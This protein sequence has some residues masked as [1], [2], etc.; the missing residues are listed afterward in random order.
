MP[1]L[2][3]DD[4][5]AFNA[6][7]RNNLRGLREILA[8]HPAHV[9]KAWT[10]PSGKSLIQVAEEMGTRVADCRLH[11]KSCCDSEGSL[12]MASP[13][14]S[15]SPKLWCTSAEESAQVP[16]PQKFR[17]TSA[18]MVEEICNATVPMESVQASTL[19]VSSV[20]PV[21]K[22]NVV[23][24]I[25]EVP[26]LCEK[27]IVVEVP[28][29]H[30]LKSMKYV[31]KVKIEEIHEQ[32]EVPEINWKEDIR[33][34]PEW[35]QEDVVKRVSVDTV[36]EVIKPIF[37]PQVEVQEEIVEVPVRL[38]TME[39]IIEKPI[40]EVKERLHYVKGTL[41]V[42]TSE[43]VIE[44][45]HVIEVPKFSLVSK[46][47]TRTFRKD[48]VVPHI[49]RR[50][51]LEVVPNEVVVEKC[52]EV[53]QTHTERRIRYIPKF[54]TE[55]PQQTVCSEEN[56]W[57]Q[58]Q[59]ARAYISQLEH[60][61]IGL[62][63][64]LDVRLQQI[65]ELKGELWDVKKELTFSQQTAATTLKTHVIG[66]PAVSPIISTST[67]IAI[68]QFDNARQAQKLGIGLWVDRPDPNPGCGVEAASAYRTEVKQKLLQATLPEAPFKRRVAALA[69]E[70][71]TAGD[72]LQG[73]SAKLGGA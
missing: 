73:L 10:N 38:P 16:R 2:F 18:T 30:H 19:P 71:Q 52:V 40:I 55:V 14:V 12:S 70:L 26:H 48:V 54:E 33:V 61:K 37:R 8:A 39:K 56:V 69:E 67:E 50:E 58:L 44:V 3:V 1:R 60:Q 49:E 17:G 36:K 72:V 68:D 63:T 7:A 35:K 66:A 45:P 31:P 4:I 53:P 62:Q 22:M 65:D 11:L 51:R 13:Q 15:R 43:E 9:W 41:D 47:E 25:V 59:Q 5:V 28:E 42:Q 20:V 27:D 24:K 29:I 32:V 34:I 46:P 57:Q 6:L 64:E 23:E 21:P